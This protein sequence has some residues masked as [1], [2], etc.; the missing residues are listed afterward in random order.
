MMSFLIDTD[1]VSWYLKGNGRVGN[2]FLQYTGRLHISVATLAELATWTNRANASAKRKQGLVDLL[3]DVVVLDATREIALRYGREEARLM[4]K[5]LAAT[6]F[7]LLIAA[8]ALTHDL[9]LV[10]H[11]VRDFQVI[12]DLMIVD[13]LDP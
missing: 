7:D 3:Q 12:P 5:G 1:I 6:E 8:T 2:R 4:D 11:N 9:V 10:T 13:W